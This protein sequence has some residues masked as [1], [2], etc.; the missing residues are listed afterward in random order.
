[1]TKS[2]KK[3]YI[4]QSAV[5]QI[6]KELEEEL[7]VILF[8]RVYKKLYLTEEGML[9]KEYTRRILNMWDDMIEHMQSKKKNVLI[10]V[11]G[12]TI[13]GIYLL[14]YLCKNFSTIYSNV[15][16][17]I[18]IANTTKIIKKVLENEIDIGI[19]DGAVPNN[20]EII[21]IEMQKDYLKV[22]TPNIEKFKNKKEFKIEDFQNENMVLREEG[23][24]TREIVDKYIDELK[25]KSINKMVIGN[26]EAIK[27]MV[28]IGLGL[29]IIST[30]AI[31]NE[32]M[33]EKLLA[34]NIADVEMSRYFHI[35]V[36]K[37]KYIPSMLNNFIEL[38]KR[39]F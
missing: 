3:M 30:L 2:S 17:N 5:S 19:I 28:E 23:S 1:M 9:F 7:G 26:N 27:K 24:G 11:G 15:N 34:F 38:L 10:K 22:V 32:I 12:S 16:F 39:G 18:Q 35:I 14:P 29:T 6:I 31:E 4:S 33:E 13:S 37:D 25:I 36:H 21:S 20:N 8:E